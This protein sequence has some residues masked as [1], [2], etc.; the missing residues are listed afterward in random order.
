M[1]RGWDEGYDVPSLGIAVHPESRGQGLGE[2]LMHFLHCAARRKGAREIM[3][4]VYKENTAAYQ[5]YLRLGYRFDGEEQKGQ[6][7]GRLAL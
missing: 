5:L 2:L 3:L 4:K 6:L 1:L 7:V